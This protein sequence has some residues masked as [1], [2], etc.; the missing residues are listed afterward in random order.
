MPDL[1]VHYSFASPNL[2]LNH[3]LQGVLSFPT[4]SNH[5]HTSSLRSMLSGQWGGDSLLTVA[6]KAEDT[7]LQTV[8]G[9]QADVLKHV[10]TGTATCGQALPLGLY[11]KETVS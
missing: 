4:A 10:Q 3:V 9:H 1:H 7:F 11:R 2:V 8:Q 6:I 5:S